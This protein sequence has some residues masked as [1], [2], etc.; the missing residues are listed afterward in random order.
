MSN[1]TNELKI[2]SSHPKT[3]TPQAI[4]YA[5]TVTIGAIDSNIVTRTITDDNYGAVN[6]G[7]FIVEFGTTVTFSYSQSG[8]IF[9]Y[10]YT[11]S[12]GQVVTYTMKSNLYA[13]QYTL[14][15]QGDRTSIYNG[16]NNSLTENMYT[17]ETGVTSKTISPTFGLKQYGGNLA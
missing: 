6:D 13:M 2:T 11:F 3:I 1:G 4:F 10:T 5:C 15:A 17:F 16:L 7:I 8:G 9:T 12:S 14:N